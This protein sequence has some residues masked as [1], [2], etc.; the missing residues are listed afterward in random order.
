MFESYDLSTVN[1]LRLEP[2]AAP[3][4]TS[5]VITVHGNNFGN[6]GPG[7]AVCQATFPDGQTAILPGLLLDST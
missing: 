7:Q 1:L 3:V 2:R 5:T 4:A 6:Y